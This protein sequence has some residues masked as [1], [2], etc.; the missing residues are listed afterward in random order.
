[1]SLNPPYTIDNAKLI[2]MMSI[3]H[4]SHPLPSTTDHELLN[5]QLMK[6]KCITCNLLKVAL[7]TKDLVT[8]DIFTLG[9]NSSHNN[10]LLLNFKELN[11]PIC[12]NVQNIIYLYPKSKSVTLKSITLKSITTAKC[13]IYFYDSRININ[14]NLNFNDLSLMTDD[15]PILYHQDRNNTF[16]IAIYKKDDI[17]QATIIGLTSETYTNTVI[18]YCITKDKFLLNQIQGRTTIS[19][20][21]ISDKQQQCYMVGGALINSKAKVMHRISIT[22]PIPPEVFIIGRYAHP[23][24]PYIVLPAMRSWITPTQITFPT[25]TPTQSKLVVYRKGNQL[26]APTT[27]N[28]NDVFNVSHIVTKRRERPSIRGGDFTIVVDKENKIKCVAK[29]HKLTWNSDGN[30]YDNTIG[31]D[32]T[33]RNGLLSINNIQIPIYPYNNTNPPP[34]NI[35]LHEDPNKPN[36]YI[37]AEEIKNLPNGQLASET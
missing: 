2:N 1:M 9:N 34:I 7:N 10:H 8:L 13:K 33:F 15:N 6:D 32:V 24:A 5:S 23:R 29:K 18:S 20:V 35:Q 27:G 26:I 11:N 36:N 19:M 4:S 17:I 3:I 30:K 21:K 31:V 14:A 16:A 22:S 12:I 25:T 28:K 37:M